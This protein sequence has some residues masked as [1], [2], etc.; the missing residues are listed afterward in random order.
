MKKSLLLLALAAIAPSVSA[1]WVTVSPEGY[2][3]NLWD[4]VSHVSVVTTTSNIGVNNWA[5]DADPAAWDDTYGWVRLQCGQPAQATAFEG[6]KGAQ[7]V[8]LGSEAGRVLALVGANVNEE[9]NSI[10]A[11][12]GIEPVSSSIGLEPQGFLDFATNKEK[13]TQGKI[14]LTV[15]YNIYAHTSVGEKSWVDKMLWYN[16]NGVNPYKFGNPE[17]HHT[18]GASDF[19]DKSQIVAD[20]AWNPE[21][22]VVYTAEFNAINVFN[23]HYFLRF[24]WPYGAAKNYAVFI[25][26]VKVENDPDAAPTRAADV[27]PTY[28]TVHYGVGNSSI[29]TGIESIVADNDA[30]V[31]NVHGSSVHFGTAADV[32]TASGV[33]VASLAAGETAEFA[34]GLYIAAGVNGKNAKF[35]VR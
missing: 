24:N 16:D 23:G 20:G 13:I 1:E 22:W 12:Y 17:H 25:K 35:A 6:E 8:D 4:D 18:L 30:P 9:V 10:L 34:P 7:I 33:R 31:V 29:I 5:G 27:A 21:K 32:Y 14:R 26:E 19:S 3:F 2:N 28:E 11:G 15:V